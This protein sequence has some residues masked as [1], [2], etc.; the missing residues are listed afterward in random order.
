MIF[1]KSQLQLQIVDKT[2]SRYDLSNIVEQ[3]A[4]TFE[5]DTKEKLGPRS[6]QG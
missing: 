3:I 4:N 2:F 1:Y 5:Y 6:F